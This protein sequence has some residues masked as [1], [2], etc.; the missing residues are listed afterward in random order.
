MTRGPLPMAAQDRAEPLAEPARAG[1]GDTMRL[2]R[3]SVVAAAA[4][5]L[6]AASAIPVA[7]QDDG[8]AA[9]WVTMNSSECE[10]VEGGDTTSEGDVD[11]YR[12][13]RITCAEDWSDPRVSGTKSV[14]YND[15]CYEGGAP[16]VYWGS[17]EL[18]GPDGAWTGWMNG[19]LDPDRGAVGYVVMVGSGGY[20][21]LTFISHALGPM[22]EP[23]AGFGL[24][25]EGEAPPTT[26]VPAD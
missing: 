6:P 3:L 16:C 2:F 10:V 15:D 24:I 7:A 20:E 25:F 17:Q 14:V 19:T 9:T 12:G 1:E 13:A 5:A 4:L 26:D 8:A 18:I 23:P 22:G 21:G 11:R